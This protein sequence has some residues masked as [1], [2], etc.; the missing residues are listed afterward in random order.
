MS[1]ERALEALSDAVLAVASEQSV[2]PIL[3]K[4]V[5]A[6]RVLVGAR[7]AALGIP[8]EGEEFS[9]FLVS[10]LTQEEILTLG[11]LP[12]T[13]GMLGAVMQSFD[14]LRT[15]DLTADPRAEGWWPQ[16]HPDMQSLLGVPIVSKGTVIGAFY[17]TNKEDADEFSDADQGLIERFAAH[18]AVVIENARLHEQNRELSIVEER[19]RLAR[20]LHDSVTQTL[21]SLSLTAE[22][23]AELVDRDP[24]GAREQTRKVAELARDALGELRTLVFELRPAELEADGLVA[25][26]RKH[27]EVIRRASGLD[28]SLEVAG[29]DEIDSDVE[30][31][32]YRIVQEAL[33]NAVRHSG[34]QTVVVAIDAKPTSLRATITDDGKGFDPKA[35][36]VR[37]K[38][39]GLTSM[40]ERARKVGGAVRIDSE[41]GRGT[42]VTF[43]AGE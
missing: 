33:N 10:G 9:E 25:T 17:L 28:V 21:F 24:D 1:N 11:P 42:T 26:L 20:D 15:P 13:H 18:A 5:D 32:A 36:P 37:A 29:S 31:E 2:A 39:L 38:H 35:L 6:A 41:P 19:N 14:S 40:E 27:V 23:A 30:R 7:Y 16:G 43:E 8:D 12:R 22:A 34:A 3:Q 4:L